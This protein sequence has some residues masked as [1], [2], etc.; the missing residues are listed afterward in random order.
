MGRRRGRYMAYIYLGATMMWVIIVMFIILSC[1]VQTPDTRLQWWC[2]VKVVLVCSLRASVPSLCVVI[3]YYWGIYSIL[4]GW[5]LVGLIM[6]S[7][8]GSRLGSWLARLHTHTHNCHSGGI[9]SYVACSL[10]F[11][12]GTTTVWFKNSS[13]SI[14]S[15]V[16]YVLMCVYVVIIVWHTLCWNWYRV[17]G[18]LSCDCGSHGYAL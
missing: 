7:P 1:R 5:V 13:L 14:T 10:G 6:R 3:Y 11:S 9:R 16:L 2:L 4:L 15:M 17:V 18:S 8:F 12:C